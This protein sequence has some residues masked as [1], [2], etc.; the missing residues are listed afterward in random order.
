MCIFPFPSRRPRDSRDVCWHCWI[1]HVSILEALTLSVS[2]LLGVLP[3]KGEPWSWKA[4]SHPFA[5][6]SA[7]GQHL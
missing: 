4:S 5:A 2:L 1:Q 7:Q 6:L 3:Q